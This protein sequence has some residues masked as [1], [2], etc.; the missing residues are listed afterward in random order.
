VPVVG[1]RL[2][3][4]QGGAVGDVEA[5]LARSPKG[6]K[7]RLTVL[8]QFFGVA[9][10]R[11]LGL[12][13]PTRGLSAT[14]P[15]GFTGQ[16][17]GLDQQRGLFR[18]WT[19]DPDIHPHEALLGIL[20]ML[21]GASS[22]EVRLLR[23]DRID[24]TDRT[25]RLGTRPHPVPLDPASWLALQRRLA[26]RQSLRTDNPHVLVTR[27]TKA[28]RTPASTAYVSHVL[29]PTGVPPRMLRCTRL[30]DLVNTMDPKLVAA[31]FG[32][33]PEGVMIYLADR[34]DPG[35]PIGQATPSL[36]LGRP[37]AQHPRQLVVAVGRGHV[38]WGEPV[39]GHRA[40][41]GAGIQQPPGRGLIAV[42]RRQMQRRPAALVRGV[43]IGQ[44]QQ[45]R[46]HDRLVSAGHDA[47]QHPFPLAGARRQAG[48]E[49]HQRPQAALAF[50]R[51]GEL[52]HGPAG[53]VIAGVGVGSLCQQGSNR[54]HVATLDRRREA[55]VV[56]THGAEYA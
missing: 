1:S 28:H 16:T 11:R 4:L 40:G 46:Q 27:G 23:V 21:H 14:Q 31:A 49:V 43:D 2:R 26:H 55:L 38:G 44:V 36:T 17:I 20:A 13:D 18:R 12:T 15:V 25:I 35:R 32:M 9:R 52:H 50:C 42:D 47:M 48:T 6:R 41:I 54:S 37:V 56:R 53:V 3:V 24:P 33:D 7:R 10:T 30:V 8:R 29:D 5:F 34:S 51:H 39:R 45:R 19:T 22:R